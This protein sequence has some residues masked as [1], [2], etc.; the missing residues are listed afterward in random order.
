LD[1]EWTWIILVVLAAWVGTLL[2]MVLLP[3][4]WLTVLA[5]VLATALMDPQPMSWWVVAA[6]A[7]LAALG[8]VAETGSSAVGA[9]KFGASKSGMAGSLVGSIAG[10][11]AGTVLIPVPIA[12]TLIGAIAG[13]GIVTGL[14]ERGV[15]GRTWKESAK[16]GTGAAAGR[17]VAVFVKGSLAVVQAG[18]VTVF[19]VF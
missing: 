18:V 13:A 14:A 7:A 11:I 17:A 1:V 6:V 2:T 8:E 10:A 15:A 9:R 4:M 12:G 3:G 19:M 5:A 16:S